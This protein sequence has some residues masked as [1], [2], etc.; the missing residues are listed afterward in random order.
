[1]ADTWP[2]LL[3]SAEFSAASYGKIR[4]DDPRLPILL[5]GASAAVRSYCGWHVT[6]VITEKLLLDGGTG[7][8]LTLPSL[9]VLDITGV[10]VLGE[11]LDADALADLEWSERG[12]VRAGATG[13]HTWPERWRSIEVELLHG[14]ASAPDLVSVVQQVVANAISSPLGATREQAGALSVM[15]STTAPGVSGGLSLLRRDL[16]IL[17]RYALGALT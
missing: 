13:V 8:V 17:D 3:T 11:A 15:W 9:H 5:E 12:S 16:D 7:R 1:M 6:P 14:Y 10:T 2:D 4:P